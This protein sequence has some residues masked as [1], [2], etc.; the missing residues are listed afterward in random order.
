MTDEAM[1]GRTVCAVA[2]LA[3]AALAAGLV[4]AIA[5]GDLFSQGGRILDLPW[6]RVLLLDVYAGIA[7]FSAWIAWREPRPLAAAGWITAL[8]LVG[9]L[10]ACAY[11]IRAWY[12]AR[13]DGRRFWHGA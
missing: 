9:N 5:G 4:A 2:A 7:L 6:G 8:V 11:V 3:A 1:P 12:Q 13:G 10:V